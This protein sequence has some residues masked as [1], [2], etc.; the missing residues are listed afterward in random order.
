MPSSLLHASMVLLHMRYCGPPKVER[1]RSDILNP[2]FLGCIGIIDS[3]LV[4]VCYL[5]NNP[6]H[7]KWFHVRTKMYCVNNTLVVSHEGLFLHLN[8]GFMGLFHDVNIL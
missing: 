6:L 3:T 2:H 4:Q 1:C 8:L 7:S 5:Y